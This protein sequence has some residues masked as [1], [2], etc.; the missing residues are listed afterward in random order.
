MDNIP[1]L[2][3]NSSV[4]T[5]PGGLIRSPQLFKTLSIYLFFSSNPIDLL[6]EGSETNQVHKAREE[7]SLVV[8][9]IGLLSFVASGGVIVRS[10][11]VV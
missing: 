8:Q 5:R 4:I 6:P 9:P 1:L 2:Q 3:F 7:M 10:G 11:L